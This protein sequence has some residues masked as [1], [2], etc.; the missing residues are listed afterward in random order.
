MRANREPTPVGVAEGGGFYDPCRGRT[1]N[2]LGVVRGSS[3]RS[4]PRLTIWDAFGVLTPQFTIT[5]LTDGVRVLK[6]RPSVKACAGS[7]D[8]RTADS[9]KHNP[10]AYAAWLAFIVQFTSCPEFD[11]CRRMWWRRL[12]P[13]K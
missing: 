1:E 6:R 9:T 8:P 11:N 4:D 7:G 10:A 5:G 2:R 12:L 13:G 3:L